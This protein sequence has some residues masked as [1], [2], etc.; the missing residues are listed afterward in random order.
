MFNMIARWRGNFE[1]RTLSLGYD[2]LPR[3]LQSFEPRV[4]KNTFPY[5]SSQITRKGLLAKLVNTKHW[6]LVDRYMLLF[7]KES[8][9][10][11]LRLYI[12]AEH[13]A[14]RCIGRF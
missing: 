1:N 13:C 4:W 11:C 10:P 9:L 2:G 7:P 14:G 8:A 5:S 12:V 6:P 3:K